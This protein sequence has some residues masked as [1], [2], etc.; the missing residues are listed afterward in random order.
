MIT[1]TFRDWFTNCSINSE[2]R[3]Q[4]S[5]EVTR[6]EL[7]K[8]TAHSPFDLQ[9][10]SATRAPLKTPLLFLQG[11]LLSVVMLFTASAHAQVCLASDATAMLNTYYPGTGNPTA[12]T[13]TIGAAR[14]DAAANT[15]P[16]A[17]GDLAFVIQMQD[18]VINNS[19]SVAYGNG[20]TGTGS[21]S[22]GNSGLYEFRRVASIVAGTVTFTAA[23][24]NSYNDAVATPT[25]GQKRFQVLRVPEF[26]SL[27]LS[28]ASYSPPSWNS[29]TGGVFVINVAGALTFTNYTID[30]TGRGF[31]GGGSVETSV[32]SGGATPRID[33]A[34]VTGAG[35]PP[36]TSGA[37]KGEGIAGTP[38]FVRDAA[39]TPYSNADLT[40]SGYPASTDYA[41]GAPGNAGGGGTQHNS[42]GGGGANGGVGGLGGGSFGIYSATDTGSCV[43]LS[44]FAP[45][46]VN[47][48]GCGGDAARQVGG[49]GGSAVNTA[50]AGAQSTKLFMGGGGG[51]GDAN[52]SAD[53]AAIAQ[54]SG[55]NGGG[56]VFM[57]ALTITASNSFIITN[58]QNG[59]PGGRDAAGGGGAGGS[60]YVAATAASSLTGLTMTASGGNGGD[61][62]YALRGNETQGPGGGGA[63]GIIA[64]STLVTGGTLAQGF[65]IPGTNSP[66]AAA[67][68]RFGATP[69]TAGA[70]VTLT[71]SAPAACL[72]P[73]LTIT[74]TAS[75]ANFVVGTAA[76]YTLS[77]QNTGTAATTA[78]ATITDTIPTGL[79]I[80][81]VPAGCTA[82]GQVV[83]CTIATGLAVNATTSFVIPVTPTSTAATPVVNTA[84]VSGGGDPVCPSATTARC[85]STTTTPLNA[86]A[87][88][89]TKTASSSAFVVGTPA[90]YTLSV[91]NTGTT[92]TSTTA[93]VTDTIPT[94]LTIGTL[95]AG[96]T[97][98]GQVVTCT[99]AAGLAV[100]ATTSFVIPV[101]PTST[102]ATP[103]VNTANVSGGGDP[104]CPSATTARC[105][106]TTTTPLNAPALTLTKTA[107]SSAFVV[108]TPASYTLT[109][110]NT[111]T[112][113]T[114]AAST[115]TDT[116]PTGLTIGTLPAG[117]TA[118][119]Q[120]VTCTVPTNQAT[121]AAAAVSFIIPVT[122]TASAA[123][124]VVNS[125]SVRGGGD[126]GCTATT[127]PLPGR[128]NPTTS[129]PLNA[130]DMT[131]AITGLPLAAAPG[132]TVNGTLTCT[133]AS[134][135]AA[136]TSVTCSVVGATLG[137]C[138][139]N[140]VGANVT[141]P[142]TVPA[143]GSL[144]CAISAIAPATGNIALTGTTSASNEINTANNGSTGNVPVVDAVNDA[145]VSITSTTSAQAVPGSV[146]AG[147]TIGGIAATTSNVTVQPA[148]TVT[149]GATT[150]GW[151][152]DAAGIVT[153]PASVAPGSYSINY[154]IC[155]NP[156]AT[157]IACDTAAKLVTVNAGTPADL[158]PTFTF[159]FTAY[160][161][162]DI[163]DVV[164]NINEINNVASTGLARFFVPFS[165]GF[166]YAF[167][168]ARTTATLFAPNDTSGMQNGNWTVTTQ[169]TGFL[170]A[171]TTPIPAGGRSR[172]VITS[173]ADVAGT[174]ANI[175]VNIVALSGG[176]VRTNNNAV[177]L[178]QSVQ[179]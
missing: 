43:L 13:V 32:V 98:A 26:S 140:G 51:A 17:A 162:N 124:P 138:Q 136:A 161:V 7:L 145:V 86:P 114:T 169:A 36:D 168:P 93:T 148:I 170:F 62:G 48:F 29:T 173:R 111:G 143:S 101:T 89:L 141:Q 4:S 125:A 175:T 129:T 96:C 103:V 67:V 123:S 34:A 117:C 152:I 107:S 45:G 87:L 128:C 100:N 5:V 130:P 9:R 41:R 109:V 88:T 19:N 47:Y 108:G 85:N 171:S 153:A 27:S 64:R 2:Q 82:T 142:A 166:T 149:G 115:V 30:A 174:K 49:L 8:I 72:V 92:A 73:Q 57:R 131:S 95:P 78:A 119:G 94:G 6:V 126:P 59:L 112:T 31:R 18:A 132:A 65:G 15:A 56:A 25:L 104:V 137:N 40:T 159:S 118:A 151:T 28:G 147:D 167:D 144:V 158:T 42:G 71:P 16:L 58:G 3:H 156:A 135:T 127:T 99:I 66:V 110:T 179:R 134:T 52:N 55:G 1:V 160:V 91:Q 165:S 69:G 176:E 177:V 33:Y 12:T 77:V 61:T 76:S 150:S 21:T 122:P 90:S 75:S 80:G 154:Q 53:N 113:A 22:Q 68:S 54:N 14:V 63:G 157:P 139:I 39:V 121:G 84:N 163:R 37:A 44:F 81:T 120:V 172:I 146:L 106:S 74:K 102:A 83:T 35:A 155:S 133:N 23:L 38:R 79:T 105:N 46:T 11:L 116:I 70:S 50:P 20:T 10:V 60:I 24:T 164:I 97:A 178:A